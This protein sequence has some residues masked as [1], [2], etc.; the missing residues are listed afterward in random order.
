MIKLRYYQSDAIDAVLRDMRDGYQRLIVD[1]PPGAGKSFTIAGLVAKAHRRV[2]VVTNQPVLA[3]QDWESLRAFGV[4]AG[5]FS[6]GL[7]TRE[8][9][10]VTVCSTMTLYNALES[11]HDVSLIVVD[12]SHRCPFESSDSAY[13]EIFAHFPNAKLVGFTGSAYR[14]NIPLDR[15]TAHPAVPPFWQKISYRMSIAQGEREGFLVPYTTIGDEQERNLRITYCI[16][17]QHAREEA[18]RIGCPVVLEDTPEKE[19]KE[20]IDAARNLEIHDIVNIGCLSTGIDI[21]PCDCIIL[22]RP[23]Q[24]FSLLLQ[25][26]G[27]AARPYPGKE[28]YLLKDYGGCLEGMGH[29]LDSPELANAQWEMRKPGELE[30]PCPACGTLNTG[31]AL[32][33]RKCGWRFAPGVPCPECG[34]ENDENAMVCS[35]CHA[36]MKDINERLHRKAYS[37]AELRNVVGRKIYCKD[38]FLFYDLYCDDGTTCS[39]KFWPISRTRSKAKTIYFNELIKKFVAPENQKVFYAATSMQAVAKMQRLIMTPSQ[40]SYRV[41]RNGGCVLGRVRY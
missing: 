20:I 37:D 16:N 22:K 41:N 13:M 11:V 25:I 24:S 26:M 3:Y 38:G 39:L 4:D 5:L 9:R 21:K 17:K 34:F 1:L 31:A 27:R 40:I 7:K 6:D 30:L 28:N 15:F 19:K 8:W 33:C 35:A 23:L 12:E 14:H 29:W 18:E 10:K 36:W 2:L 32:K